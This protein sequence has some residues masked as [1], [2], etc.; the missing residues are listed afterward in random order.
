MDVVNP[1]LV[2]SNAAGEAVNIVDSAVLESVAAD[3]GKAA[4]TV[5]P[6]VV[7]STEVGVSVVDPGSNVLISVAVGEGEDMVDCAV[8]ISTDT[9]APVGADVSTPVISVAVDGA[10]D[11]VAV[12]VVTSSDTGLPTET[13]VS[14]EVTP[15]LDTSVEEKPARV[16]SIPAEVTSLVVISEVAL[17]PVTVISVLP[18]D[19]EAVTGSDVAADPANPTT[20]GNTHYPEWK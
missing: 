4:D 3:A 1:A 18:V 16:T 6:D 20:H 11:K 19:N 2:A 10:G 8:A 12:D 7:T 14:G 15:S 13:V 17:N 5:D 9:E